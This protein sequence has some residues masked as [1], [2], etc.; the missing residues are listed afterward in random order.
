MLQGKILSQFFFRQRIELFDDVCKL[1]SC[2]AERINFLF[3]FND[4]LTPNRVAR[5]AFS[6]PTF[7]NLAYFELVGNKNLLLA[8]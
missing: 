7:S 4:F 6:M 5:L 3:P 1:M 2:G 8:L